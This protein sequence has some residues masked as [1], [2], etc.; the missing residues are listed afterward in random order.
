MRGAIVVAEGI[1]C[2]REQL[3]AS[4]RRRDLAALGIVA[5]A[6]EQAVVVGARRQAG[7]ADRPELVEGWNRHVAF[8]HTRPE[9]LVDVL[10][11]LDGR[12][13]LGELVPGAESF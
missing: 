7:L 13:P 10:H 11:P 9:A 12:A 6:V 5:E 3:D 4:A 1:D 8:R 2:R